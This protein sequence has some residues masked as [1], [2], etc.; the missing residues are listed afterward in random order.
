MQKKTELT[1]NTF[2]VVLSII[3]GLFLSS[4]YL[5][6]WYEKTDQRLAFPRQSLRSLLPL[7]RWSY[8]DLYNNK[9]DKR[10]L[11]VGDS[12]AEG[13]G[14]AFLKKE[15]NYS[16]GHHLKNMTNFS[17]AIAANSDSDIST[18][19]YIL[20]K[21]LAKKFAPAVKITH[22]ID[23]NPRVIFTFY[24][25]NDLEDYFRNKDNHKLRKINR[26]YFN[27]INRFFPII[28]FARKFSL[29]MPS[30][31]TD[32]ATPNKLCFKKKCFN[33][34]E[35]QAASPELSNTQITEAIEHLVQSI[36]SFKNQY[37]AKTCLIYIPSP[38]TI[39]SRKIMKFQRYGNGYK[40]PDGFI[41]SSENMNKSIYIRNLLRKKLKGI[42]TGFI[43]STDSLYNAGKYNFIHGTTD[44][45]H[46]NYLGYKLLAQST[47]SKI[48][49]CLN[50][51]HKKQ[52]N[53]K[54][55]I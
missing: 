8:P 5:I 19:L 7:A 17:Y 49:D 2:L 45:K 22:R 15:Y 42:N 16:L 54:N 37:Y 18:Q 27:P 28:Y 3:S 38:A 13:A 24:E 47:A 21:V 10:I 6:Y 35:M 51:D 52:L 23:T 43:D 31:K 53:G 36:N 20:K 55:N 11:I 46:F 50:L 44:P 29:K 4:Q 12:Y 40:N 33:T 34:I 25:G 9:N 39:Y 48:N 14:D 32:K 1:I 41:S 30:S 26:I